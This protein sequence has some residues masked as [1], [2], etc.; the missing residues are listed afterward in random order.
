MRESVRR[1]AFTVA[2]VFTEGLDLTTVVLGGI[3]GGWAGYTY[4]P[5]GWS[6]DWRLPVSIAVALIGAVMVN[7][8]ADLLLMP[9][10]R[11]LGKARRPLP[12]SIGH[13][14]PPAPTT[15]GEGLAQ[16]AA[17]TA[18]DAAHRAPRTAPPTARSAST[19]ARTSCGTNAAGAATRTARRPST[20]PPAWC[21]TTAAPRTGTAATP[22][23]R[24]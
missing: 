10:R 16:V 13:N 12:T 22:T 11:Q 17:A 8:L 9:M 4:Y 3:A 5:A 1:V 21:S 2:D 14:A 7:G 18:D 23:S 24:C 20:S 19:R 15:L 6:D